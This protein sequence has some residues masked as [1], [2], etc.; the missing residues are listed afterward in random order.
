MAVSGGDGGGIGM[1]AGFGWGGIQDFGGFSHHF[2]I[3]AAADP[4]INFVVCCQNG[5]E[6]SSRE[7]EGFVYITFQKGRPDFW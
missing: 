1:L 4:E 3:F 5:G 2:Y 7:F 6:V